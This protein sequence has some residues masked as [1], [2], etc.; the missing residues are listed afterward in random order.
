MGDIDEPIRS[1]RVGVYNA[2]RFNALKH[3]VLSQH[4]VL[5]GEDEGEYHKV[6]VG[7]V[8]EYKPAGPK[9]E[10]LVEEITGIVWRKR[11]LRLAE[12]TAYMRA[13]DS[14]AHPV[15]IDVTARAALIHVRPD[16]DGIATAGAVSATEAQTDAEKASLEETRAKR[17]GGARDPRRW[18]ARSL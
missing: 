3:G 17:G 4:T 15:D 1:K 9:E 11:R 14:A 12:K 13:L 7:F 6:L 16:F 8:D 18:S 2:T 5:P 10:H